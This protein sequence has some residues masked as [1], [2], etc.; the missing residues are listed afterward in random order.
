MIKWIKKN[1]PFKIKWTFWHLFKSPQRKNGILS[2]WISDIKAYLGI[3]KNRNYSISICT[4]IG[5][6]YESY[7]EY[8]LPSILLMDNKN[9]IELSIV[10]LSDD[11]DSFFNFKLKLEE[12]WTG[13][14]IIKQYHNLDFTRSKGFNL[15]IN[16]STAPI[17]FRSDADMT[18]PTN[19]VFLCNEYVSKMG[20]WYPVCFWLNQNK[21][22]I[23]SRENGAWHYKGPGMFATLRSNFD[24]VNGFDEKFITWGGEDW[25][26]FHRF[27]QKGIG[28][29]RKKCIGLFHNWHESTERK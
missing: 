27:Y 12:L 29:V 16:Q 11:L 4:A 7:L 8:V 26:I 1:I 9:K 13:K 2:T 22:R 15:A 3:Q 5:N 23:I 17:I 14:I 25:D 24:L 28:G 18:L 20:N 19:L 21:P 10:V 6:R